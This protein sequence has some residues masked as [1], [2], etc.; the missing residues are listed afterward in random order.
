M[1]EGHI[2]MRLLSHLYER[3]SLTDEIFSS[4]RTSRTTFTMEC[5]EGF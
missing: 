2:H 1:S 4:G 5:R 3:V